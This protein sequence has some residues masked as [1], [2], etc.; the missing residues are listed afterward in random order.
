MCDEEVRLNRRLAADMYLGVR[1]VALQ[2]DDAELTEPDDPR[3]IDFVVEMRRYD[4]RKTL[5][6]ILER[7][8]ATRGQLK[9][10]G[11]ALAR[12]HN[13]AERV[14]E[15]ES[16]ALAVERRFERNVHELLASVE[17]HGEIARVQGLERF[18]HG[19]VMAHRSTFAERAQR[20]CVREGHGDLRAEHIL[21]DPELRIVDCVEFDARLRGLDVADDLAFLLLDLVAL[22]AERYAST[23]VAAYRGAGGD[24]G[25]ESLLA[26]YAAHRGL[27]RAKVALLRAS[28]HPA[29]SSLRGRDSA[30]ARDLIGLAERFA[31]RAR[32][33]LVIVVCG[34]PASGKSYLSTALAEL[35]GLPHL[36]SDVTRKG[37]YGLRP[38]DRASREMYGSEWNARTYA[39]LGRRARES[40][41]TQ[42][43]AIVD[44]T[45][46][47]RD[48]RDAFLSA[49]NTAAPAVFLECQAPRAVATERA[50]RRERQPTRASD[51]DLE[52]VIRERQSWEPL[53]EVPAPAHLVLR[54]D[55]PL[56]EIVGDVLAL[57]DRRLSSLPAAEA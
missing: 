17:Q 24:P 25:D 8:E 37:L 45:F 53:E 43:G 22:G 6:A 57:L 15:V 26:F 54:T 39:E 42:G 34:L 28:Q 44:A 19:F 30:L 3:S 7:G 49:S 52:V 33:P 18:A 13:R 51:A 10:V 55:R 4:E 27:I 16:P 40:L 35:S 32:L 5:A 48:D 14:A 12:F 23:L 38:T 1:G 41:S 46:R 29:A 20:G 31:W 2:G 47:H 50:R 56:E 21:L 11:E 9:M 36:S